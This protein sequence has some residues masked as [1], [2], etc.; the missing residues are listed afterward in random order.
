MLYETELD[1]CCQK[2]M[3]IVL[4]RRDN[5]DIVKDVYGG[6]VD[7]LMQ[8]RN[9]VE[10]IAFVQQHVAN[11]RNGFIGVDKLII[12]KALRSGYKKPNQ[13]AHKVLA[14]RVGVRDPGNK[15]RPGD[16]IEFVYIK[17]DKKALQ[18]EKIE[19]PAYIFENKIAIDYEHYITN[20]I[21][22]PLQQL[23]AL[24]LA[25]IPGFDQRSFDAQI[26]A[27]TLEGEKLER[28]V[29]QIKLKTVQTLIF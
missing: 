14:D 16:R 21:M 4:K 7:I 24:V 17:G 26:R 12:T 5:A 18:G 28:K 15:P 25:D 10:A 1:K 3:G 2:S 9:V 19:T 6:V 27:L 8:K 11:L 29:E 13:I 20:Q 22:K 23:F